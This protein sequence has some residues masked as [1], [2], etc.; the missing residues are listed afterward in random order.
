LDKPVLNLLNKEKV[1]QK[2]P[3]ILSKY[4]EKRN[5]KYESQKSIYFQVL[6]TK[7]MEIGAEINPELKQEILENSKTDQWM[8]T[9]EE[10]KNIVEAF[11]KRLEDYTGEPVVI[12]TKG[13]FET[14]GDAIRAGQ[15]GLI[16]KR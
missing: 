15:T 16:N 10:R 14:I 8:N 13:L 7:L 9:N 1:I 11:H 4:R 12:K 5:S 3:D 2:L 6:G